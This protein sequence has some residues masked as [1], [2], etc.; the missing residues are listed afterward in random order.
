VF[1][2]STDATLTQ[3]LEPHVAINP[4]AS[5]AAAGKLVVFLPGTQAVPA[6]YRLILQAAAAKGYHAIGLTY[7]NGAAVGQLCAS[8]SDTD[9]HGKVRREVI[10]GQ[11]LSPLVNVGPA[12]SILNRLG[13]LLVHLKTQYPNEAWGQYLDANQSPVWA[14]LNLSGHSQGGGHAGVLAKLYSVNRVAYFSSPADWDD[15]RN[16]PAAW[17]SGP[18][19]TEASRQYGF[20]HL[21][22]PL[23]A[24]AHIVPIWRSLQLDGFGAAVS[25][26]TTPNPYAASHQLNT[27]ATP[28]STQPTAAHG[29]T[30]FDV[31][32]PKNPDGSP[33]FAPV[34][35]YMLFP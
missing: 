12:D 13:K 25:V 11:D 28:G 31:S 9:C 18:S 15:V 35:S 7:V 5:V 34:W 14:R 20:S 6:N 2:Q 3:A 19:L 10:T 8:S 4:A 17:M 29:A 33:V 27:D 32:V 21:R 22:D 24:Y 30:V 1:P 26:D 16:A 23:V